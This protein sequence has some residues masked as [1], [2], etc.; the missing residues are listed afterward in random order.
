MTYDYDG[1][2]MR[3]GRNG[4]DYAILWLQAIYPNYNIEDVRDDVEYRR[5]DVDFVLTLEYDTEQYRVNAKKRVEVKSDKWL[6]RGNFCFEIMRIRHRSNQ[7]LYIGWSVR[8]CAHI[9]LLWHD[10]TNTMYVVV[11]DE[12]VKGLKRYAQHCYTNN[13][14]MNIGTVSTDAARTTVNIYLPQRHVKHFVYQFIDGEWA[15]RHPKH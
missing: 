5:K 6:D 10:G 15:R 12:L 2:L 14:A 8:T 7:P 9:L 3:K 11:H 4:E 1:E 13:V